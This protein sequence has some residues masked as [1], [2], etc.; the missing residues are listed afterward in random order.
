[1]IHEYDSTPGHVSSLG[2]SSV[3]IAHWKYY[4]D[5]ATPCSGVRAAGIT[6]DHTCPTVHCSY[7]SVAGV[8]PLEGSVSLVYPLGRVEP[9]QLLPSASCYYQHYRA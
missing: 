8:F 5:V 1:M 9:R 6:N 3:K 4:S 2:N 7:C